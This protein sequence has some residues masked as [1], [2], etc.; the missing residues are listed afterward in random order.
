MRDEAAICLSSLFL[1]VQFD[2]AVQNP[3]DTIVMQKN[4]GGWKRNR[5]PLGSC[6]GHQVSRYGRIYMR[7]NAVIVSS[8]LTEQRKV[9]PPALTE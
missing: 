6:A 2:R 9:V 3:S 5:T 8:E 7:L 4:T 1:L